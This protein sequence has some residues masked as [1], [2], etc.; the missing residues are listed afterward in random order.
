[1]V[2]QLINCQ[3]K[4]NKTQG[5]DAPLLLHKKKD[6]ISLEITSSCETSNAQT[7]TEIRSLLKAGHC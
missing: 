7:H 6:R 5:T 4:D 2:S 3:G 1:M